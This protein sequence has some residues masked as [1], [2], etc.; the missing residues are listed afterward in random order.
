M[1]TLRCE[2]CDEDIEVADDDLMLTTPGE[3]GGCGGRLYVVLTVTCGVH[4]VVEWRGDVVCKECKQIY[5]CEG[6]T[7]DEAGKR[8]RLY[9]Q[10]PPRGLCKCGK[11][12]FGGSDFTMRPMCRECAVMTITEGEKKS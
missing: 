12:L 9:P 10:A 1:K 5:L 4:G 3:H 11:R 6:I 7:V 8:K 2:K